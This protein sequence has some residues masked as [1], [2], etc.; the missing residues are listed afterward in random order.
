MKDQLGLKSLAVVWLNEAGV[1]PSARS[2][3]YIE[4]VRSDE[5]L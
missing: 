3:P 5:A 4:G 1:V 2:D